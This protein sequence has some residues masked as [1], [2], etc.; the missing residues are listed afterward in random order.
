MRTGPIVLIEDDSDDVL[1]MQEALKDLK[2]GNELVYFPNAILAM[3]FLKET[4]VQPFL[5]ICDLNMP[6]KNGLDFKRDVDADP[7]LKKKCIPF[8]FYSTSATEADVSA[9]F[10]QMSIQGFFKKANS[11]DE[12]LSDVTAIIQYWKKSKHPNSW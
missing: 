4:V 7:E 6:F 12:I 8:I 5:I 10:L 9:A 11:Y 1:T 2:V 3:Q